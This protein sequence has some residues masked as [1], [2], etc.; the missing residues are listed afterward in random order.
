MPLKIFLTTLLLGFATLANSAPTDDFTHAELTGLGL[1]YEKAVNAYDVDSVNELHSAQ[2]FGQAVAEIAGDNE[3]EK[4]ELA[5]AFASALD[6]INTKTIDQLERQGSTLKFL[7]VHLLEGRRGPLLRISAGDAYNYVFLHPARVTGPEG[8]VRI[9]DLY[10]ATTG[11]WIS[12]TL[13][14]ANRLLT[15]PS[16]TFLGKIFGIKAVNDDLNKL[17]IELGELRRKGEYQKAYE[18]IDELDENMRNQ[19]LVLINSIGIAGEINDELYAKE[20]DRM[21]RHYKDDPRAAFVLMDHYV[22]KGEY[23]EAAAVIDLMEKTYGSDAV[24]SIFRSNLELA[25]DRN[26]AAIIHARKAVELEPDFENGQWVLVSALITA[27][28]YAE[29][30]KVLRTLA[31]DFGYIFTRED[32]ME[33]PFYEDFVKTKEFGDWIDAP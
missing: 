10:Y 18:L 29:S 13:G 16:G 12:R 15:N 5:K 3:P 19:R 21:A 1:A 30:A 9:G 25:Q 6:F 24:M 7:R 8:G 33:D 4:R 2:H 28:Q 32:F 11:E 23:E 26:E 27:E 31:R 22:L 20:L 17:F 14:I